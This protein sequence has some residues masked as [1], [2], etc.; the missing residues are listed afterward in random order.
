M[1]FTPKDWKNS[2]DTSTPISAEALEDIEIRL[3]GYTDS[4]ALPKTTVDAKGDL[5]VGTADDTVGRRAVGSNGQ[6]L[7]ADSAEAD[8]VKWSTPSASNDP[9]LAIIRKTA[10]ET[11]NN[12]STLQNDDQLLLPVLA[13]E[14]WRV[15]ASLLLSATT[16]AADFKFGFTV[17]TGATLYWGAGSGFDAASWSGQDAS[18]TVL[19]AL[20]SGS[21][22]LQ[23]GLNGIKVLSLRAI[24]IG[25][26]NTGNVRLQWAQNTATA[27]DSKILA[28]SC[29]IATKLS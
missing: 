10:D 9:R 18:S 4:V 8:G 13:N 12:S 16:T 22:L 19:P 15:E 27:S 24:Y 5:L 28:N 6:V 23:G 11:V 20:T 1:A 2:P 14:V 7:T 21:T 26:A 17:P 25:A 3:S 29:L